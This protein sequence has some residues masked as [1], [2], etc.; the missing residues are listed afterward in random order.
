MAEILKIFVAFS[1]CMNFENHFLFADSK[2]YFCQQ[3][4]FHFSRILERFRL[5]Y[6]SEKQLASPYNSDFVGK[7]YG[8]LC[9]HNVYI[10]SELCTLFSLFSQDKTIVIRWHKYC[11]FLHV[12]TPYPLW[13]HRWSTSNCFTY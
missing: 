8:H 13:Q 2:V 11:P 3:E 9:L 10:K 4:G 1:E 5:K 7:E 6:L 12:L